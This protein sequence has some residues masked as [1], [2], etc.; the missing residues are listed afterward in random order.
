MGRFHRGTLRLPLR[1][2]RVVQKAQVRDQCSTVGWE[3][4]LC[5]AEAGSCCSPQHSQGPIFTLLGYYSHL[6][7]TDVK[8]DLL[9]VFLVKDPK[10]EEREQGQRHPR[11][12]GCLGKSPGPGIRSP[13]LILRLALLAGV[14]AMAVGAWEHLA[15]GELLKAVLK[16]RV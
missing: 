11:N 13:P 16:P 12:T 4:T 5:G 2:G 14:I 8:T 9:I 10:K 1:T 7:N 15:V 3:S 6:N